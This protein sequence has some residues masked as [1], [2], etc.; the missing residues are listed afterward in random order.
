MEILF[1]NPVG[2]QK[3]FCKNTSKRIIRR[4]GKFLGEELSNKFNKQRGT[5]PKYPAG[6]NAA[7]LMGGLTIWDLRREA[8]EKSGGKFDTRTFH[9]VV[10]AEGGVPDEI[11]R[12]RIASYIQEELSK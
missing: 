2:T 1:C 5:K 4:E 6:P 10:L 12:K 9:D 7:L 8:E 11:L 3:R